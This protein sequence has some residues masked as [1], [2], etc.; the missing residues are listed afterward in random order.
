MRINSKQW[1][2][3]TVNKW[4]LFSHLKA[5]GMVF[6]SPPP[7]SAGVEQWGG[8]WGVWG[9]GLSH[10]AARPSG[11]CSAAPSAGLPLHSAA[12]APWGGRLGPC[13]DPGPARDKNKELC[14]LNYWDWLRRNSA[15]RFPVL[16]TSGW[17]D[18]C[19]SP[20]LP[21]SRTAEL[22]AAPCWDLYWAALVR[23]LW[24]HIASGSLGQ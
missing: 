4:C 14:W 13:P 16:W 24:L 3:S 22:H 9:W 21:H 8:R 10:S 11:S 1:E 7:W 2:L 18:T 5:V 20:D 6:I 23:A 17:W 12:A 19:V 15:W